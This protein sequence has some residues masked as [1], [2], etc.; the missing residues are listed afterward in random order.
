M[1]QDGW[2]TLNEN[3]IFAAKNAIHPNL[4]VLREQRIFAL[5]EVDRHVRMLTR[6]TFICSCIHVR[7]YT[8]VHIYIYTHI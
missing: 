5:E 6:Y 2:P 3:N 1:Y 8:Y 7:I 4:K